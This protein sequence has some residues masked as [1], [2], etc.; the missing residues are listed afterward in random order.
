[1]QTLDHSFPPRSSCSQGK[2]IANEKHYLSIALGAD[3]AVEIRKMRFEFA[4]TGEIATNPLDK[5]ERFEASFVVR[6][7]LWRKFFGRSNWHATLGGSY[8]FAVSKTQGPTHDIYLCGGLSIGE[9][10][11][12][13]KRLH[14][15][16]IDEGMCSERC[17]LLFGSH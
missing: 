16:K 6:T 17:S 1:M 7:Q 2:P 13:S 4:V 11:D 3:L 14:V 8:R 12:D 15:N 9:R 10:P 5:S